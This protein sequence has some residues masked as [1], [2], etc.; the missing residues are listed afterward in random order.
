VLLTV[1]RTTHQAYRAVDN[2]Q[3]NTPDKEQAL[4]LPR[5]ELGLYLNIHGI[6]KGSHLKADSVNWICIH[7]SNSTNIQRKM[8]YFTIKQF[9]MFFKMSVFLS[10]N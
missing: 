5:C 4:L 1:D 10:K 6:G 3:D 2:G 7:V 9:T 8:L